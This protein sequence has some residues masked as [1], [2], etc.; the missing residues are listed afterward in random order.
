MKQ[1]NIFFEHACSLNHNKNNFFFILNEDKFI[2]Y[3]LQD[4]N[5]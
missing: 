2:K 4:L 1:F 3:I 5:L